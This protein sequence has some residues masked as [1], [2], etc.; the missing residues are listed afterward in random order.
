[1]MIYTFYIYFLV[2]LMSEALRGFDDLYGLLMI[3]S[4]SSTA[5]PSFKYYV[6]LVT[7]SRFSAIVESTSDSLLS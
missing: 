2:P 6:G 4:Q 5:P 1:M 3:R 7:N